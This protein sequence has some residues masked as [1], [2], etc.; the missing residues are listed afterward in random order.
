[1]NKRIAMV[2]LAF[3]VMVAPSLSQDDYPFCYESMTKDNYSVIIFHDS[4]KATYFSRIARGN[5]SLWFF[6]DDHATWGNYP[7]I[8][9]T[10]T[11]PSMWIK[12]T[13][14]RFDFYMKGE[15]LV[16]IDKGGLR[17]TYLRVQNEARIER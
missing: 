15:T 13:K 12:T 7:K 1:M 11:I 3:F 2:F 6:F 8:Q 14:Y 5:G 9:G 10:T 17:R 4:A 16:E